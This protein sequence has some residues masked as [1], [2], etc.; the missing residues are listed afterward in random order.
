KNFTYTFYLPHLAK[1]INSTP[2]PNFSLLLSVGHSLQFSTA[3]PVA[4]HNLFISTTNSIVGYNLY[5]STANSIAGHNLHLGQPRFPSELGVVRAPS[6]K[7][8]CE[9][10]IVYVAE[11]LDAC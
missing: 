5:I 10:G 4:G 7:G 3:T 6:V 8:T 2:K 9:I 11:P 1:I